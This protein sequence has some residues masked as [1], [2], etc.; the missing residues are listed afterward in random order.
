VETF[1]ET[2]EVDELDTQ[3]PRAWGT[4]PVAAEVPVPAAAEAFVV[5]ELSGE[6][7][8]SVAPEAGVPSASLV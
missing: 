5:P 3:D 2:P 4:A 8:L 6:P 7:P 1:Y